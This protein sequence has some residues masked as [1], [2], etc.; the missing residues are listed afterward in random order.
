V[1]VVFGFWFRVF[2]L[3]VVFLVFSVSDLE[4]RVEGGGFGVNA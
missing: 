1:Y 2:G 4:F 3:G